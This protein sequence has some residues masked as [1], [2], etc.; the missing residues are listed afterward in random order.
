M[1][2]NDYPYFYLTEDNRLCSMSHHCQGLS[3]NEYHV[4]VQ[5]V[6]L[7][8]RAEMIADLEVQVQASPKHVDHQE[9]D[10]MLSIDED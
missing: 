8:A 9:A 7:E 10:A 2:L 4:E 5:D 1:E 6:E 3:I